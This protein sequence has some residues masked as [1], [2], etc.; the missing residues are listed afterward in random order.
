MGGL[1]LLGIVGY[2]VLYLRGLATG[3]RYANGF[4]IE[5]CPVCQTGH[6]SVEVRQTRLAGIPRSRHTV[7]CNNCHSTLREVGPSRWRYAVDGHVNPAMFE[8]FNGREITERNLELLDAQPVS[9]DDRSAV[10][11]PSFIDS[12]NE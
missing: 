1:A 8:R 10:Q 12:D 11:P 9:P 6:L 3:E 4:I 2:I 5:R 7:R